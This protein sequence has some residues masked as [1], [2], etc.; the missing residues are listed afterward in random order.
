[1]PRSTDRSAGQH[2]MCGITGF[3][4]T[5]DARETLLERGA[6]M[7]RAITSRGPDDSGAWSLSDIGLCLAFRR[8]AILDLS[9]S[10][11]QPMGSRDERFVIVFN[12]EIYNFRELRAEL[13]R[14]GAT[15]RG[16]SDTEV[17]LEGARIWGVDTTVRR[18]DGMF[19]IALWDA[20]D[21]TLTLVR[22]RVG[23]KPLY[24]GSQG[25]T[26]LFGSELKALVKHPGFSRDVNR[27]ALASYLRFGYVPTPLSIYTGIHKLVPGTYAV[28]ANRALVKTVTF[29]SAVDVVR[30]GRRTE[31]DLGDG[32][33]VAA[34]DDLLRGSVNRRMVADVPLGAFLSGGID[35]STIVAL[36]QAQ[37]Q[38]PVKTFT[39]GFDV[40]GYNEAEAAK[41]IAAHLGTDHHE[42]YVTSDQAMSVIPTLPLVYDEPFADSS[43]IPTILVSALARS[44]VTVA[45]SGD[46]GDELFGGYTR[47]QWA[48]TIWRKLE[49]APATVREMAATLITSVTP[50]HWDNVYRAVEWGLPQRLRVAAA[51]DKLHKLAELAG[52]SQDEL[53]RSLVSQ[54]KSP[55]D[56]ALC[57]TELTVP[58]RAAA[59]AD[60]TTNFTERMM[61]TDLLTYLPDDILVKVDRASMSVS[62]EARCPLL[63]HH[64]IEW[65]WRTP[66]RF[67]S[68]G[69]VGKWLLREVLCQYVP[70]A[71][72]ERPKMGFGVPIDV[73]LRGPLREWAEDLLEPRRMRQEGFLDPEPIQRAWRGHVSGAR[74]DQYR[75][76]VILMF[77]MWT[78]EWLA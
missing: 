7:A 41:A 14:A 47:Y 26:M 22:D 62:L 42:L 30:E 44:E 51:G 61:L 19:A 65:A 69:G 58:A 56:I 24:Y 54:W 43:Q 50:A 68:R 77:Q 78:R 8:L 1:M 17:I 71:L 70:R 28:F 67:K 34:L 35:S 32:D 37:S 53:Y 63:D 74:N 59:I 6:A 20:A 3:W 45:L 23:K 10:G 25:A 31:H 60:A 4:G 33:A 39:I 2:R 18:L 48:S 9:P 12:G 36:M 29:W 27:D 21:R 75:L 66:M 40:P 46:G 76:W 13:V 64:V 72:I 38:K 15:F 55:S 11:H 57:G 49:R 5:P 16:T 52:G 73:W